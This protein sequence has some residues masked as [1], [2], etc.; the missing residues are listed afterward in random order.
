MKYQ[1]LDKMSSHEKQ[2][3]RDVDYFLLNLLHSR[4][5][6]CVITS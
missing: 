5:P 1:M 3:G 2:N 4:N 6:S